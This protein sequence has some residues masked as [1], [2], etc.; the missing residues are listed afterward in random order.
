MSAGQVLT[1]LSPPGRGLSLGTVRHYIR[2]MRV[3]LFALLLSL[4]AV[5]GISRAQES[6]VTP[7]NLSLAPEKVESIYAPPEAS[8]EE[9]LGNTGAVKF[10]LTVGFWT[11]YF[12]RG[13]DRSESGGSEDSP[14]ILIDG[15]MRFDLG[16]YPSLI[17]GVFANIYDSDPISRFQEIS[18][19]FALELNA[20][21][22]TLKVGNT[23]YIYPDRDDF[24]TAE[25]WAK[26]TFDD[27]YFFRSEDPILHPYV[28]AAW[29]YDTY[30]GLYVELGIRHDFEIQ[31]TPLV[32]SPIA[33]I[34][35]VSG[36][37]MFRQPTGPTPDPAF[38]FGSTGTDSGFQHYDLG[39]EVTFGLNSIARIPA[40][41]GRLDLKGYI[42]YTDGIEDHLR[43]DTDLYGGVG[44]AFS[45]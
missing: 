28:L 41:Y 44:I 27:S 5:A 37:K 25:V 7:M 21:P 8:Q 24:N 11:D 42:F 17:L 14:N 23:F 33:R 12:F 20:R 40:R 30:N 31:D 39:L 19:Y 26:M 13:I 43:A 18:P 34:A 29:D 16:R 6:P 10:D 1:G 35:Y 45:Y 3:V 4:F 36:D 2:A 38:D 22:I 9:Q 32:I 15:S